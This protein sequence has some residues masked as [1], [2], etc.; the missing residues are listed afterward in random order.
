MFEALMVA[1][2]VMLFLTLL[3]YVWVITSPVD[4]AKEE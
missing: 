1:A 3:I 2:I 4:N